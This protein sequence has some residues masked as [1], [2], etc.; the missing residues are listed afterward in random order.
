MPVLQGRIDN[1][2]EIMANVI[3]ECTAS[4]FLIFF[5]IR[6]RKAFIVKTMHFVVL[7]SKFV[8]LH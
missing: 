4:G 6:K 3:E 1:D 7:N 5:L 2:D 8:T